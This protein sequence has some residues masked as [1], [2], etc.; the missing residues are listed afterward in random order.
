MRLR[1]IN[2][3]AEIDKEDKKKESFYKHVFKIAVVEKR[4]TDFPF[5]LAN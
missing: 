1:E 4:Y 3:R 2:A 5:Y